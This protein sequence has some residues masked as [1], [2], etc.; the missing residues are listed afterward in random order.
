MDELKL[1]GNCLKGSRGLL[2]FDKSFDDT[3][4]GRLCKEVFTHVRAVCV[5]SARLVFNVVQI[6]GVP[7]QA[8]KA[9][10]FIDHI[11][12]FSL[13]DDKIWFRNFQVCT[14]CPYFGRSGSYLK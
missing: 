10:P 1:T 2:S 12:T 5:K 13:L 8:R 4:W 3:E 11:L 7:P 9:K 14:H 6:F